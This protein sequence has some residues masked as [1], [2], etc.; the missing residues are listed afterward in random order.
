MYVLHCAPD[1]APTIV[2]LAVAQAEGLDLT[3]FTD[4]TF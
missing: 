2:Q 3:M 4:P 1:S